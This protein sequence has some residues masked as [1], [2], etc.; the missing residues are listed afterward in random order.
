MAHF[1]GALDALAR[2][3]EPAEMHHIFAIKWAAAMGI[4]TKATTSGVAQNACANS[5]SRPRMHDSDIP[6]SPRRSQLV[7]ILSVAPSGVGA[8]AQLASMQVGGIRVCDG[9]A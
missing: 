6:P 5:Q 9:R 7:D 3:R 8:L 1:A 2:Q 4:A